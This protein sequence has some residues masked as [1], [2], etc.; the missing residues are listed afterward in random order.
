LYPYGKGLETLIFEFQKHNFL[1]KPE[2][3]MTDKA[4]PSQELP[5]IVHAKNLDQ[6]RFP[7]LAGIQSVNLK[8]GPRSRKEAKYTTIVDRHTGE[9]HHHALSIKTFRRIQGSWKE[10][11]EGSITLSSEG[12]D[13]IQKLI[14]F[15]RA[16]HTGAESIATGDY[17]ILT[18]PVEGA[19]PAVLQQFLSNLSMAGK[20]DVLTDILEFASKDTG[21]L[22]ILL[23]RVTQEPQLFADAAAALNLATYK[24]AVEALK[25]LI[26]AGSDVRESQF[27][28]ILSENPW[29][30]GS[31]YSELLDQRR[32]T[33]DEQQDFV[34][35][36]TIDNYIEIIEIKTPLEGASLFNHD[37]SH[38]SYYAGVE[39]SKVIGQVQ[40]YLEK[41]DTERNSILGESAK[42]TMPGREE[43]E[44][45]R[46]TIYLNLAGG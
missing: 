35:R 12:D 25:S 11:Q 31:E 41:L 29:M 24:S 43:A 5:L 36:R 37:R 38:N 33:R 1:P 32:W 45:S 21:L 27:Q 7:D 9:I 16:V 17:A 4:N 34:V 10:D 18:A 26:E 28:A 20:A 23:E 14:D 46:Q 6:T 40:N 30:F 15:L 44:Q 13:E 39:L 2:G 8:E 3:T 22:D 42:I 19:D